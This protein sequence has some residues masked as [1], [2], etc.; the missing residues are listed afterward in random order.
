MQDWKIVAQKFLIIVILVGVGGTAW[1]YAAT[2]YQDL[3]SAWSFDIGAIAQQV[4]LPFHLA[5]L[6]LEDPVTELPV[7]VYGVSLSEIADT[8]GAPRGGGRTHEGVDIFAERGTPIFS[9]TRGYVTRV[10]IGEL[11]GL[12]VMVTGPGGV[13]YYYAHFDRIADGIRPG[14]PVTTDTVLGFTG[15]SGNATGTPP[16]LHFGI[17]EGRW[18]AINPY[19]LLT[20][21]SG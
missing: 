9:V 14:L 21:R 19:P 20:E 18:D 17:Y 2:N 7:P 11:G 15:T 8:W 16:H 10:N 3:R 6:A 1:W 12:N 5:Q 4:G 13:R